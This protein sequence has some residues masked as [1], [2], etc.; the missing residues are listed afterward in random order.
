MYLLNGETVLLL[1]PYDTTYPQ[2]PKHWQPGF[3]CPR[4]KSGGD[5]TG[6][7]E[8]RKEPRRKDPQIVLL[9]FSRRKSLATG[10]LS[11]SECL[12]LVHHQLVSA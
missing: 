6:G 7:I 12:P 4:P 11:Y 8:L 9:E 1:C 3:M 2:L 10:Q 5:F